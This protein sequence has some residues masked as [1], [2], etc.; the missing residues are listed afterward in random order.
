MRAAVLRAFGQPLTVEDVDIE[1]PHAGEVLVRIVASGVCR[2]DLHTAR[3]I[4]PTPLPVVLGHEGAGVVEEVGPGVEGVV[5]GDHVVLSWLPTCGSCRWCLAGRPTRCTGAA[6][7]DDGVLADGTT[8]LRSRGAAVRHNGSSTFAEATVVP[9]DMVVPIDRAIPLDVASLLGCA[10]TTGTGAVFNAARVGPGESVVVLG[11]GGV[12]SSAVQAA[13]IAGASPIVAVDVD[14]AK[15]SLAGSLGATHTVSSPI[16]EAE[17]RVREVVPEG[18]DH[19][20]EALGHAPT[21]EVAT[22]L[23]GRGGTAVL[24]GMAPPD[25]RVPLDPLTMVYEERRIVG[26]WYGSGS[27]TRDIPR[28]LELFR[29]GLLQLEPLVTSRRPLEAV[30][31]ALG[32]IETGEGIRTLLIPGDRGT[33]DER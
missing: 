1:R 22:R 15:A 23:T 8:R 7:F 9:A 11:C 4:H 14:A 17:A 32:S 25:A 2:S 5:A 12:G 33:E 18:A 19:V 28:L 16:E 21:I 27:P 26:C 31:D 24:V 30:N 3:G 6:S 29:T 20:I 10:V 13:R